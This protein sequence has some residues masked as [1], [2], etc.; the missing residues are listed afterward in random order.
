MS[1]EKVPVPGPLKKKILVAL[2]TLSKVATKGDNS[3]R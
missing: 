2:D 3:V 1:K